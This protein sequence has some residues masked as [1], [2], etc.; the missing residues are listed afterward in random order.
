MQAAVEM[1]ENRVG[2]LLQ[3]PW[4]FYIGA[5]VVTYMFWWSGFTKL[6]DFPGT[7]AE[8]AHFGLNPPWIF[9]FVT[10]AVQLI[11][12]A[13]AIFGGRYAWLG[14][15][16]LRVSLRR[17][18]PLDRRVGLTLL[19]TLG[20]LMVSCMLGSRFSQEALIAYFWI[21]AALLAVVRQLHEPIR[22]KARAA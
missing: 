9:A 2:A 13:L 4:L 17:R 11:G 7:Q 14:A 12:S 15:A 10:V 21:L 5:V 16:A 19:G 22:R 1:I 18:N 3:S 20:S 8:M 6:W